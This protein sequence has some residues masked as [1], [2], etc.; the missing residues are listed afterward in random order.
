MNDSILLRIQ[1]SDD[2]DEVKGI[3]TRLLHLLVSQQRYRLKQSEVLH[4]AW[5]DNTQDIN[6]LNERLDDLT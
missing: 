4:K 1:N 2:I 6:Y 3:A 5:L